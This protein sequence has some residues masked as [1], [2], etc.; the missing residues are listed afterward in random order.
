MLT[1]T[2]SVSYK[3]PVKVLLSTLAVGDTFVESVA[4]DAGTPVIYVVAD[5]SGSTYSVVGMA[6]GASAWL[7]NT[8]DGALTEVCKASTV[9]LGIELEIA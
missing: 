1:H 8:F 3:K 9:D 7:P 5:I 4:L 6:T 2:A